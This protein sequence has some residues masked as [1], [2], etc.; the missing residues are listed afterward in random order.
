MA[1]LSDPESRVPASAFATLWLVQ[2]KELGDEF[3]DLDSHGMP[4]GSFALICRG[5][6]QEPN[7][8]KALRQCLANFGLFLR[9]FRGSLIVRGQ[10]AI[11]AVDNHATDPVKRR[12]GEETFLL[13]MI[14][15]LCWLGGRRITID[16]AQFRHSRERLS[17]DS[18]LWGFNLSFGEPLL[19]AARGA[20][21]AVAQVFPAHRAAMAGHPFP[22]S[23]WVGSAGVPASAKQSLRPL[24]NASGNGR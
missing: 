3:F 5:L 20:V 16:R 7:L 10:R 6:I 11:I 15:L 13:L 19:T 8:E 24:A 23:A 18:L 14:S 22:Q 21:A 1:L 9:D 4:P 12:F 2:I 17:D